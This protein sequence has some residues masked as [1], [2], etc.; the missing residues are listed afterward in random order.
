MKFLRGRTVLMIAHRLR[1]VAGC[2]RIVVLDKG[3]VV[4]NGTHEEL[5]KDCTLYRKMYELQQN[6]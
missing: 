2:D 6:E 4:G 1:S 5:M 3:R